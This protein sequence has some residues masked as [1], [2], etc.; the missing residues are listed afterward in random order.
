M[1]PGYPTR[2]KVRVFEANH[3]KTAPGTPAAALATVWAKAAG[4]DDPAQRRTEPLAA[5]GGL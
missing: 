2:K 5:S 4:V 3:E 1:T